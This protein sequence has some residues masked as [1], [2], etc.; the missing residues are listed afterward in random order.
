MYYSRRKE[1]RNGECWNW[2]QFVSVVE[3]E[4]DDVFHFHLEGHP[5]TTPLSPELLETLLVDKLVL[6][7][8][9]ENPEC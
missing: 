7:P 5:D 3:E 9:D 6:L 8:R 2:N 1:V 4:A